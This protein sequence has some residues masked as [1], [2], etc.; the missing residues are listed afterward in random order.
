M[1]LGLDDKTALVTGGAGRIGSVDAEILADEGAEVVILDVDLDGA[2]NVA[3][4]IRDDGGDAF[5][6]DCDLTDR[7][8]VR[9][10]VEEVRDDTGGV[11]VL[12]NNA[13]VVDAVGRVEGYDDDLWDRDMAVNLTGTYNITKEIFPAMCDRGW[14]RVLTMSSMAG[15]EG[16]FGQVS[17][18]TTK[19]GLIGFG[20]TL[21]LEGAQSGV[22]SNVLAPS[23]VVGSL[24]DLPIEQL[25]NVNEKWAD[26]ARNT[27]M[28]KL[29]TEE[30]VANTIA[31]LSSEQANYITGQVVGI[32]GGIDLFA[33]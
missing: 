32:T 2:E 31:Y 1:E 19:A 26:I 30:D 20:K 13:G 10:T 9:E 14:G 33:F 7:D 8:D 21:A 29:G 18:S 27:P 15:W 3:E 25:E 4:G 16:G 5:A 24:S 17:Y 11:D 22:T 12:V 6:V 23:I 28:R